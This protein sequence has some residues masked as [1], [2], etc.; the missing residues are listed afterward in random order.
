[1]GLCE[2][3]NKNIPEKRQEYFFDLLDK[4]NARWKLQNSGFWS[5]NRLEAVGL[6]LG[7]GDMFEFLQEFC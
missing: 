3:I 4:E 7:L 1:M 2:R 6:G 5:Q